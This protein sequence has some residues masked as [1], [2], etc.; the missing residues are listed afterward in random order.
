MRRVR[1]RPLDDPLGVRDDLALVGDE[2]RHRALAAQALDL[3]APVG[4]PLHE[5]RSD[6]KA[7]NLDHLGLITGQPQSLVGVVAGM[8]ARP[9]RLDR[10][11]ADVELHS[12]DSIPECVQSPRL[13]RVCARTRVCDL[14]SHLVS[15]ITPTGIRWASREGRTLCVMPARA[16]GLAAS[17]AR[18]TL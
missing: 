16:K 10:R 1:F 9:G 14:T 3:A 11:P 6:A 17:F 7:T 5:A 18:R 8:P 12:R 13:R 2:D 15:I 4:R